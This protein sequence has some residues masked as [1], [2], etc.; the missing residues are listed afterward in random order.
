MVGLPMACLFFIF[1]SI[2]RQF[3]LLYFFVIQ[4]EYRDQFGLIII[5]HLN[6]HLNGICIDITGKVRH[7][8]AMTHKGSADS[9]RV[10]SPPTTFCWIKH[11][12]VR[13][14][15][16]REI[17]SNRSAHSARLMNKVSSTTK[18]SL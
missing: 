17:L 8:H 7:L 11:M 10:A 6:V 2:F 9:K 16:I 15:L 1:S 4:M 14:T 13:Q 3:K 5:F 12:I 18:K